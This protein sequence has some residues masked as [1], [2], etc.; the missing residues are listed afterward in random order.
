MKYDH[1]KV[2]GIG[3]FVVD[4]LMLVLLWAI[5][6]VPVSTFSL[7]KMGVPKTNVLSEQDVRPQ[8]RVSLDDGTK[9]YR[10]GPNGS[11][12]GERT[13]IYRTR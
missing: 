1:K 6:M 11:N 12:T 8:P 4:A 10:Q 5:L 2:D 13:R 9:T 7:L 3:K